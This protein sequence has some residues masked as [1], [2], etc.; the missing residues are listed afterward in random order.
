LPLLCE[1]A[2][3]I[4][5]GRR[6]VAGQ[7]GGDGFAILSFGELSQPGVEALP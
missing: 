1:L 7:H 3:E 4:V 6:D 5:E 2:E